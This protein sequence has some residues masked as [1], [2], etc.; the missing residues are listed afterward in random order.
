VVHS[1]RS[2]GERESEREREREDEGGRERER[3]TPEKRARQPVE[4]LCEALA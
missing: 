2:S 3:R 1:D 4:L